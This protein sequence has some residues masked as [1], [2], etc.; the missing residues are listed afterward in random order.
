M[1][2]VREKM[3]GA[4][5]ALVIP[6]LRELGF[7]GRFPHFRRVRQDRADLLVF[8]FNSA[9]GS[10]VVEIASLTAQEVADHWRADLTLENATAYDVHIRNRLG[11]VNHSDHWF[12]FGKRNYEPGHDRIQ[13]DIVYERVAKDVVR[14]LEK[15]Q[16]R[17]A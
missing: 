2:P 4:L 6:K 3:N 17:A 14:L 15:F 11:S 7:S 12:V 10:F 9:G 1:H 5:K 8:Q 13:P 16:W